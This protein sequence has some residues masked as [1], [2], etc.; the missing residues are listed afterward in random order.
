MC[1]E[2]NYK[3]EA[4]LLTTNERPKLAKTSKFKGSLPCPYALP[5]FPNNVWFLFERAPWVFV[6]IT[7]SP[8]VPLGIV[9]SLC[10][11]ESKFPGCW[12]QTNKEGSMQI[13]WGIWDPGP[14]PS[15]RPCCMSLKRP[16]QG[17]WSSKFQLDRHIWLT[18]ITRLHLA[19]IMAIS[20]NC[21]WVT[22]RVVLCFCVDHVSQNK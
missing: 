10:A 17:H 14:T 18:C 15:W 20:V 3:C 9:I 6:Y 2:A 8:R 12:R 22:C 4:T 1:S 21:V 13:S 5:V 7:C 19:L 16:G 11:V